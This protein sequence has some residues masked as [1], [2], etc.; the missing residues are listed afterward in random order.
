MRNPRKKHL[1]GLPAKAQREYERILAASKRSGRYKGREKEVAARTVRKRY[2]GVIQTRRRAVTRQRNY[3]SGLSEPEEKK[4]VQIWDFVVSQGP[5]RFESQFRAALDRHLKAA[6][7]PTG[8]AKQADM[9]RYA[10]KVRGD[11]W[12]KANNTPTQR[13]RD[14]SYW[15]VYHVDTTK[16][17]PYDRTFLGS[18]PF[19]MKRVD[20]IKKFR[21]SHYPGRLKA[22]TKLVA[23]KAVISSKNPRKRQSAEAIRKKFAGSIS[24]SRELYFPQGT[25]A[26]KLVKLGKLVSI[27]TE[28]GTIKPVRG[29]AWLCAD[30]KGKLHIG[31]VSGAPLFEGPARDLGQVEKLEY[32]TSKP[33]LGYPN[34]IIWFH[35]LGEETGVKPTLRADGKGGLIF[36]G[37]AY[38][39]TRQGIEN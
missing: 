15:N 31:S 35:D 11:Q 17:P 23:E 10:R 27:T 14:Y 8:S 5:Y 2:S 20:A 3:E 12:R 36:R 37:G 32:E 19:G 26:G 28:A 25:P 30:T 1:P 18:S 33:H 21:Q 22:G 38:R 4:A 39:L 9:I 29:T 6:G 16:S 24:G 13:N 34:P 7:Y